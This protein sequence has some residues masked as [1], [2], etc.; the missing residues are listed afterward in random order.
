MA[1]GRASQRGGWRRTGEIAKTKSD[2]PCSGADME[3]A[4]GARL[5]A[6][7]APALAQ[8]DAARGCVPATFASPR[9]AGYAVAARRL[10]VPA[11]HCGCEPHCAPQRALPRRELSH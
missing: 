8:R 1:L 4:A 5:R 3:A 10:R 9:L 7:A 2:A 6:L 11:P